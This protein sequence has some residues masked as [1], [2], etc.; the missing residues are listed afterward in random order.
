METMKQDELFDILFLKD[1]ITWQTMI[2]EL[3]KTEK[4][5]PWDIDIATLALRFLETLKKLKEMD[6]RISGKIILAA[7]ILLRLK[8]HKLVTEDLSELDKLIA[9]S[10]QTEQEF[11]DELEQN[12]DPANARITV[13]DR[14]LILTPRTPQ[15]RKRKVSV[16]DLVE[17]LQ[18]A[19]EV[20]KR[21]MARIRGEDIPIEIPKRVIDI[22]LLI[23]QTYNQI[24]VHFIQE[25]ERKI[26]SFSD[27]INK[28][29]DRDEK[30]LAFIPLLHL[31]TQR[32]IDIEQE[33]HL[34]EIMIKLSDVHT[35]LA[36]ERENTK[37]DKVD[38]S[39]DEEKSK[40]AK[41]KVKKKIKVA[42]QK[43]EGEQ[44]QDDAQDQEKEQEQD[45]K[46]V[47]IE[48]EEQKETESDSEE[49]NDKKGA[50][51]EEEMVI[52][53]ENQN[54]TKIEIVEE[55]EVEEKLENNQ[56]KI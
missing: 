41:K 40:Y 56:N 7:A 53:P 31:T 8:S 23:Q 43:E 15:P 5:N 13:D 27:L 19:L 22:N 37:G 20:K 36:Q 47:Q 39:I 42:Q 55:K 12:F 54:S 30:I 11:Y 46:E 18:K 32:K 17:A 52:I 45:Q 4:M 14:D 34:A 51:T 35:R 25:K 10:S 16:F 21:R 28:S 26:L 9:M 48:T 2:Y 50:E 3:V 44:E 24:S 49:E 38:V 29:E 33:M 1:D 6:F